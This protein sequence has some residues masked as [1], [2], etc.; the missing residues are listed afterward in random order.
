VNLNLEAGI[1]LVK[2]IQ[3]SKGTIALYMQG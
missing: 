2:S 1:Q 3:H